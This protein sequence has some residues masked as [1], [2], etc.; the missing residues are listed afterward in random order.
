[1][2]AYTLK[3]APEWADKE[4]SVNA[5][6]Y[7]GDWKDPEMRR[8]FYAMY[9]SRDAALAAAALANLHPITERYG[10]GSTVIYVAP[11]EMGGVQNAVLTTRHHG[12]RTSGLYVAAAAALIRA[13]RPVLTYT[14]THCGTSFA[15]SD[16]RAKYCSNRC[17]QAAKYARK[18][19]KTPNPNASR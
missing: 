6:A 5:A 14:C 3:P 15:A 12:A 1:M 18:T 10:V 17:Q 19:G 11:P 9:E 2:T 4:P 7:R 8:A 16:A 13:Q